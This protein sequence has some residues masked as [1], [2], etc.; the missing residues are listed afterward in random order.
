MHVFDQFMLQ[1]VQLTELKAELHK[2]VAGDGT[3]EARVELN[4]TPRPVQTDGDDALPV[5]Q[6]TAR[7]VCNGAAEGS[8]EP[9]FSAS[10]GLE[11]LYQQTGGTPVDL[12][13]FSQQHTQLARQVY[14]LLQQHLRD[15]LMRIGLTRFSLPYDLSSEAGKDHGIGVHLPDNVH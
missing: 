7:L 8:G 4:L 11:A 6:L 14:P 5:Y 3:H 12:A 1:H 9:V 13:E 10:V 2:A 15:L